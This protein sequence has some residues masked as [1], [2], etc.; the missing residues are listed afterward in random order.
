M[1]RHQVAARSAVH[2]QTTDIETDQAWPLCKF[3][4]FIFIKIFKNQINL[5]LVYLL[6]EILLNSNKKVI[7]IASLLGYRR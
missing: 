2:L 6:Q 3:F 7:W 5:G 4:F 1:R